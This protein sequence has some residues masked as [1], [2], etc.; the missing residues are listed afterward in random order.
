MQVPIFEAKNRLSAL[1]I[2]VE[3]GTEV[4]I[5]RRGIAVAK[6]I[7][8]LPSFDR[9][10]ARRAA[11]GLRQ[12]SRGTKLGGLKIKDLVSEGRS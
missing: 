11:E 7:P 5:T 10:R 6:L 4:T 2:E 12:A 3:R 9:D 1:V 8:I